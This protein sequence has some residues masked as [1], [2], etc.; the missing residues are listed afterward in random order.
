MYF[1][2]IRPSVIVVYMYMYIMYLLCHVPI[3]FFSVFFL[4]SIP[5]ETV[6]QAMAIDAYKKYSQPTPEEP[7]D[8]LILDNTGIYS[9]VQVHVYLGVG[10]Y[11]TVRTCTCMH[12][13]M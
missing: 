9:T 4:K 5:V 13:Y 6:A 11:E 8:T 2:C 1:N 7:T 3:S 12:D 10:G